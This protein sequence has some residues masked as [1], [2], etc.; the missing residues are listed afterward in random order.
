[1]RLIG[2]MGGTFDPIHFGHLRMA[3]ELSNALSADEVRFIPSATPPLKQ[4]STPAH[5]RAE[6]VKLAIADNPIFQLDT[7]ELARSG[8]S[9][10]ID[11]LASLR[12]ELGPDVALCWLMGSDAF[13]GL[14]NWHHWQSLLD[15]CHIVVAH[16]P[17][18]PPAAEHMSEALKGLWLAS[19]CHEASVLSQAAHGHILFQNMTALDISAT[20]IRQDLSQHFNPRYLLPDAVLE[21]IDAQQLYLPA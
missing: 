20:K 9:Y 21:Y 2:L 16:R 7:R 8:P 5:H 3:Q 17:N 10:T 12:E 4:S 6:M 14:P 11:T 15:F 1:M 19:R 13:L 18:S